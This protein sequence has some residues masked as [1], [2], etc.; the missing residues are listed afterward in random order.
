MGRKTNLSDIVNKYVINMDTSFFQ[1]S[2]L[3]EGLIL[4]L[5]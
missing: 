3:F 5:Y 2:S 4:F 1:K